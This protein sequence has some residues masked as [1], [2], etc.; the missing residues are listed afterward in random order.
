MVGNVGS[1]D[2][3]QTKFN[4]DNMGLRGEDVELNTDQ[5]KP[6]IRPENRKLNTI[7]FVSGSSRVLGIGDSPLKLSRIV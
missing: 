4:P 5:I 1:A 2:K 6:Q 3:I 7:V